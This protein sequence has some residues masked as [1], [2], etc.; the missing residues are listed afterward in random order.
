MGTEQHGVKQEAEGADRNAAAASAQAPAKDTPRAAE[1]RSRRRLD[2]TL[3]GRNKQLEE[4]D[5]ASH[6]KA[7]KPKVIAMGK[8][9]SVTV[10]VSHRTVRVLL[11]E[12]SQQSRNYEKALGRLL[13]NKP[14][15]DAYDGSLGKVWAEA[16]VLATKAEHAKMVIDEYN[17]GTPS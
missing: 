3:A 4:T 10:G 14:G 13:R 17:E 11:K 12:V 2:W 9:K 7:R 5:G 1:R 15:T 8:K 6:G 16:E